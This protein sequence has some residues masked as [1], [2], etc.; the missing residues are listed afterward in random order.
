MQRNEEQ[1]K[2]SLLKNGVG[3]TGQTCEV[4]KLNPY[5]APYT[6]IN[7]QTV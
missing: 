6:I 3:K 5:L 1:G 4:V 2:D 7:S